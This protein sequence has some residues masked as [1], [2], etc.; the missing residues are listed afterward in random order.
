M[1]PNGGDLSTGGH[2]SCHRPHLVG[3]FAGVVLDG[4]LRQWHLGFGVQRVGA[5][6][7]MALLQK[8]VVCGLEAGEVSG[9]AGGLG[10]LFLAQWQILQP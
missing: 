6:V 4:E 1:S 9:W 8:C 3:D 2:A 5:V 7:V 10:T